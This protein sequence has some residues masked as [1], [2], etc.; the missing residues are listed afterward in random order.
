MRSGKPCKQHPPPEHTWQLEPRD[1]CSRLPYERRRRDTAVF[2]AVNVARV[3]MSG[4][5]VMCS[6][7]GRS[8]QPSSYKN[9]PP[10]LLL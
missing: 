4:I 5:P 6:I 3:L 9:K 10:S 2:N 8:C 1:C 7:C